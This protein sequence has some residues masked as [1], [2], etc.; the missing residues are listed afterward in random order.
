MLCFVVAPLLTFRSHSQFPLFDHPEDLKEVQ[1]VGW[2]VGW[3][4][5]DPF[6]HSEPLCSSLSSLSIFDRVP[7]AG[8]PRQDSL[9]RSFCTSY[10]SPCS[11]FLACCCLVFFSLRLHRK[12][13]EGGGERDR[14]CWAAINGG[15]T[16]QFH[17]GCCRHW[18]KSGWFGGCSGVCRQRT[19]RAASD[20]GIARWI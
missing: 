14:V 16:P 12:R 15:A 10:E 3:L 17:C 5:G 8:P 11:S 13:Q 2:L 6:K 1:V 19:D 18:T 9:F 20:W 4:V 7:I